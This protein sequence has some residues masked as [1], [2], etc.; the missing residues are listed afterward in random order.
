MHDDLEILDFFWGD[1]IRKGLQAFDIVGL[2]GN[3]ERSPFQ[4]SW[5]FRE[6]KDDGVTADEPEF[7]SGAVGQ[8]D[9]GNGNSVISHYGEIERKCKLLNGLLLAAERET[10]IKSNTRFDDQFTFQIKRVA[11][12]K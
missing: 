2:D 8:L 4:P 11:G 10:L 1:R 3:T 7:L 12:I 6:V 5:F 9:E